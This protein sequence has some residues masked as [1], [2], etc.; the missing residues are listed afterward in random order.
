MN[1][2]SP[3]KAGLTAVRGP[4]AFT[5]SA[6]RYRPTG[7]PSVRLDELVDVGVGQPDTGALEQG[8]R[9]VA[10]HGQL[11]GPDLGHLPLRPEQGHR[12]RRSASG[13]DHQLGPSGEV[14]RQLGHRVK[15]CLVVEQL[16][17][18]QD[19]GDRVRHRREG[20]REPGHHGGRGRH[21]R[22]GQGGED[23]RVDRLD[24][25]EG[26]GDVGQQHDRVVVATVDRDPGHAASLALGPLGHERRLAVAGWGDDG[27]DRLG[28]P[29]QPVQQRGPGHHPGADRGR[30]ELRGQELEGRPQPGG[31]VALRQ[32]RLRAGRRLHSASLVVHGLLQPD[33]PGRRARLVQRLAAAPVDAGGVD[34]RGVEQGRRAV[35]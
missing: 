17:V 4:P 3:V 8:L 35:V 14:H 20:G 18:V 27:D 32:R 15:A 26:H 10:V 5:A 16:Q 33:S 22:G 23:P 11:A 7:Q 13:H 34:R 21:A 29:D 1:R 9:L 2:S 30:A 24:P 12:Q 31:P 25:V 19:E 6:A 28:V